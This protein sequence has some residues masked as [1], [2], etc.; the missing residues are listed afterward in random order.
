M[1]EA[2]V[3]RSLAECEAVIERGRRTFIEVGKALTEIRDQS[4]YRET[5]ATFEDYCRER[6]GWTR[7]VGYQYIE[8]AQV[9][10]NVQLTTQTPPGL[11]QAVVLAPLSPE[12]QRE[13]AATID[14][15]TA[16]VKEVR[17]AVAQVRPPT[18]A[19]PIR[20]PKRERDEDNKVVELVRYK[21]TELRKE[22]AIV[23]YWQPVWDAIDTLNRGSKK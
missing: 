17:E 16:T 19:K 3:V 22:Y 6:W 1:G 11:T 15:S 18:H 4:L 9:A 5:H 8:A 20:R 23:T 12:Q 13:V 10:A 21:L 14:F 7:R 2:V